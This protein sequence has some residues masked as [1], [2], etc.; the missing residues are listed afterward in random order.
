M[1][2]VAALIVVFGVIVVAFAFGKHMSRRSCSGFTRSASR[3]HRLLGRDGEV[4]A[5][6]PGPHRRLRL[7]DRD[8]RGPLR[9][10]VPHRSRTQSRSPPSADASAALRA[11]STAGAGTSMPPC[12]SGLSSGSSPRSS[13][14]KPAI[15]GSTARP[16]TTAMLP[17][18]RGAYEKRGGRRRRRLGPDRRA[19]PGPDRLQGDGLRSALRARRNADGRRAGI[20][21]ARANW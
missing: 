4:P 2:A 18:N 7:R 20:P 15:T 6:V 11:R 3:R 5:C 9:G 8:R 10:R 1:Y 19:R 21:A 12:R 14:R 16:T 13:A 17:P